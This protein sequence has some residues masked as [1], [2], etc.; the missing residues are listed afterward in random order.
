M[1]YHLIPAYGRDYA[2]KK[3]VLEDWIAGKDFEISNPGSRTYINRTDAE[4]A[5]I[6]KVN[7]RYKNRTKVAAFQHRNLREWK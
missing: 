4:N 2:S 5:G 1:L 7:I 6:F 3:A